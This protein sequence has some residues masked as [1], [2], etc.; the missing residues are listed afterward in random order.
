M[1]PPGQTLPKTLEDFSSKIPALLLLQRMGYTYLNPEQAMAARGRKTSE[2]LLRQV[3]VDV[4]SGRRFTWKGKEYPL[5]ANAVAEIVRRLASPSLVDGLVNASETIY[6]HL[7]LGVTVTEFVDG[8]TAQVTVP[9][10]DWKQPANNRWHITEEYEVLNSTGTGHRRP[11]VVCFIN[12][13]PLAIIE[14]KRPDPHNANKDMLAEGISQHLRNQKNEEIPALYAYAQ[15]LL[16]VDSLEGRYATAGTPRKFWALWREEYIDEETF[17]QLKNTPLSSQQLGA[18]FDHRPPGYRRYF[19]ELSA[20]GELVPTGQDRLIMSLLRPD[21]LM[22]IASRFIVYDRKLGK[23]VARY[24]QYFGVRRLVERVESRSPTGAREGGVIWHTTGSGKSLTMVFLAKGLILEPLL[25][26]CRFLIVTDRVDLEDQLARVFA[27][28]GAIGSERDIENCKA[29][30]GRDLAE[31]IGH[32]N[33]RILFSIINKFQTAARLP[34]CRNDSSDIIVLIDE[35]HRSQGGETHERMRKALPNAA[36]V[37]FTGTPLLKNEKT[38]RRFG[39][40]VHAYPMQQAVEDKAVVPLL[41]EER[42]PELDTNAEAVDAWFDRITEGLTE[43]QRGDLKK[44]FANKGVVQSA[45]DRIELIAHDIS[46]HFARNIP[47][48]MK[49]QLATDSKQSALRYQRF[50]DDIGVVSS[51]VVISPPDTR[52][53]HDS[54]DESSLPEV[55]QWWKDNVGGRGEKAYT[56]DVITRFA[57]ADDPQ[58]LIVVDKLLTGFDEPRNMVLYIDKPL[59][60]HNLI[61]AIAR[62]NRLHE[63]KDFGLLIDYRGILKELDMTIEAYRELQANT[64]NG[65][66]AEDLAGLYQQA[67]TEYKKLPGLHKAVWRFFDSVKNKGDMEQ[68]RQVLIPRFETDENGETYDIREKRRDDF[69]DAL[70]AFSSCLEIALG[71]AGLYADSG[72]SEDDIATYKRDLR[73]F[74][75]VRRIARQDAGQSVDYSA[76][77]ARIKKLIDKHVVGIRVEEPKGV[78]RIDGSGDRSASPEDWSGEKLRNEADLIRARVKRSIEEQLGDDPYA[79]KAFSELLND[80]IEQAS[81]MF[82]HPHAMFELFQELEQRVEA[83]DV[84]DRPEALRDNPHA[85]AYFGAFQTA[86]NDDFPSDSAAREEFV[87]LAQDIDGVVTDL[88]GE[89]SVNPDNLEAAIRKALLPKLFKRIGMDRA[90]TVLDSVMQ[91]VRIGVMQAP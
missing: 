52:E 55:Q 57:Q 18:M 80:A 62:V 4:L 61:Q 91:T 75:A 71:S 31:R 35:G 79:Q 47:P 65:Y 38:T 23:V 72:F 21:R 44:K 73:H 24:Q 70:R 56:K 43:Q 58:I 66:D 33:D 77:E 48:G 10:I 15:L 63:S 13:I 7:T 25:K 12:G 27:N 53:G 84:P 74:E 67:S 2:F 86:M 85:G 78:Y 16:S 42:K 6:T 26:Q 30:T 88:V 69:Y 9:I 5:S 82:D 54:I 76:Y 3:L 34:E 32:G 11:D 28:A 60:Q 40:I 89:H 87:R 17:G 22:D 68:Y 83:R 19:D 64:A 46:D 50:L 51:A 81:S 90:K 49:G 36:Y 1:T 20:Q 37:A 39:S 59:K 45:E 8:Q 14:A 41:Y 29:T